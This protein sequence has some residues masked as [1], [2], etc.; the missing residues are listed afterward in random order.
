MPDELVDFH[1]AAA[2]RSGAAAAYPTER[3]RYRTSK[4]TT[5]PGCSNSVLGAANAGFWET[6][7]ALG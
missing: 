5:K 7:P 3:G 6:R 2:Q 1:S 4:E